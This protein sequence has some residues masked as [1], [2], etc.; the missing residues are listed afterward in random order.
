MLCQLFYNYVKNKIIPIR[1]VLETDGVYN[2]FKSFPS[3]FLS[4]NLGFHGKAYAR[5]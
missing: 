5:K 3:V 2:L 1:R 4:I